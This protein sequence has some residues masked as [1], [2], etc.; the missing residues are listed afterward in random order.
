MTSVLLGTAVA[1]PARTLLVVCRAPDALGGEV[2]D[3]RRLSGEADRPVF[4]WFHRRF[5]E[6]RAMTPPERRAR[7]CTATVRFPPTGASCQDRSDRDLVG[8]RDARGI[9]EG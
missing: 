8:D 5:S 1:S 9:G 3:R 2:G 7:P 4:E 6:R